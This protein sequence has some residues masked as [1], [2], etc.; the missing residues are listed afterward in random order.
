[1]LADLNNSQSHSSHHRFYVFLEPTT[2]LD[3]ATITSSFPSNSVP[4]SMAKEVFKADD[5]MTAPP[6]HQDKAAHCSK[7]FETEGCSVCPWATVPP[8]QP[9]RPWA[10]S[11]SAPRSRG[12]PAPQHAPSRQQRACAHEARTAA[13]AAAPSY[14]A[15]GTQRF[16]GKAFCGCRVRSS[17]P[18]PPC[19]DKDTL[20]CQHP[21]SGWEGTLL[22]AVTRC[23]QAPHLVR[24]TESLT[25]AA[26]LFPEPS[27]ARLQ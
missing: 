26:T 23:F 4:Y 19:A 22:S 2:S 3:P 9:A 13:P 25:A 10:A 16:P 6:S 5:L 24:R 20:L 1:M 15:V 14:C 7:V 21:G 27:C 8:R 17:P 18:C 12:P 11:L